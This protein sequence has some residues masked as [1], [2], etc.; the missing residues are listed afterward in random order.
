MKAVMK[1]KKTGPKPMKLTK[2]ERQMNKIR[3]IEDAV[4]RH[5]PSIIN[6]EVELSDFWYSAGR[7][8]V[9]PKWMTAQ[10]KN[11]VRQFLRH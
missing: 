4:L 7:W 6:P 1:R 5:M 3:A 2:R 11:T 10:Q 9:F 8:E